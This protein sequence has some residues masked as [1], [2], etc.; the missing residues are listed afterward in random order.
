MPNDLG[1]NKRIENATLLFIN[2]IS[3]SRTLYNFLYIINSSLQYSRL[4]ELL[5]CVII[6]I[7]IIGWSIS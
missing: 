2:I 4:L 3:N 6:K 1:N 7:I 5:F